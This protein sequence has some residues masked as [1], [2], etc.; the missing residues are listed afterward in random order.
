VVTRPIKDSEDVEFRLAYFKRQNKGIVPCIFY[1]DLMTSSPKPLDPSPTHSRPHP[2]IV[3]IKKFANFF[4]RSYETFY[5]F[6]GFEQLSSSIRRQVMTGQS[7]SHCGFAV[8]QEFKK[9][10]PCVGLH[11]PRLRDSAIY[12]LS[13]IRNVLQ[14]Q[15]MLQINDFL[16]IRPYSAMCIN[17]Q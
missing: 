11:P 1:Q 15:Q 7:P 2:Q 17:L 3:Q 5:C 12:A 8:L 16:H 9:W 13:F 4:N 6:R 14:K 10:E